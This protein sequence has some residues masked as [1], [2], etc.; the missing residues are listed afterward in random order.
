MKRVITILI[1]LIVLAGL[2]Y[3]VTYF[4]H[5][6]FI[7]FAFLIG[8][9]V[10]VIIWFFTS[11]GGQTTRILDATIQESTGIK[12]DQ[13]KHEFS[14][15]VAFYTSLIYTIITLAAVIYHYKSYF[16]RFLNKS[17]LKDGT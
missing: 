11:K 14:P 17:L 10:T 5:T 8:I 3:G 4:T 7:D 9:A 12:G 6:K 15:N 2:S 13:E 1:T 16:L